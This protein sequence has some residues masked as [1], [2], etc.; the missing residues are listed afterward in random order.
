MSTIKVL[1][2][3]ARMNVGGTAKYV[4]DLVKNIPDSALATGFV[5][6]SEV[7][8]NVVQY[9]SIKRIP[10]LGRSI[11]PW[12]DLLSYFELRKIVIEY[13][14]TII[15]SHTFKA[16]VIARLL[17]RKYKK[18]HTFHGHLFDDKS[19]SPRAKYL[20]T[21]IEKFLAGRTDALIS[22]GEKVGQQIR[23]R[24]IGADKNWVS[25]KPGVKPLQL[26]DRKEARTLLGLPDGLII[27]WMARVTSVKNPYL[28]LEVAKQ[29]P[30]IQFVMAGGG[31]LLE[32]IRVLVPSNI[33]ILGWSDARI[34]WSAVDLAISTSDNEGV[35]IA[36][37]EAQL[38]GIPVIATDVGSNSEVIIDSITGLICQ[39]SAKALVSACQR[40]I[41]D[42]NLRLSMAK[43]APEEAQKR[44]N[45][46]GMLHKHKK[47]YGEEVQNK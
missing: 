18:V 32:E 47:L 37:I 44:F 43:A 17:P 24:G 46:E 45:L 27:G 9:L 35:P 41:S 12:N 31:D 1:H 10:H 8:D 5:Q 13:Q 36:L 15:H 2:V 7:E 22:V 28:L 14:P 19:F 23:E 4:G 11:S 29:L 26:I 3:I 42:S 25:I 6:G 33:K 38:A 40:L 30:E 34:F 21:V 16:G 20:I 39:K